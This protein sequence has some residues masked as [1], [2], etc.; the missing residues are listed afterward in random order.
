MPF[1]RRYRH[2]Q[3]SPE[4]ALQILVANLDYSDYLG[5]L[6]IARVFNGTLRNGDEAG[7]SKPDGSIEKV[8]ITKL[9]SFSGLK[10]ID[11]DATTLG[12]IVA[13]A[14][15]EGINIGD[16]I[17]SSRRP[18]RCRGSPST[19]PRSPCNLRSILRRFPDARDNSS[20]HAICANDC[21]KNC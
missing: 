2:P 17:T 18:L 21:K 20:P 5:R 16:T 14:G 15:V 12:D 13:V 6:A 8:K 19:S 11:I 4:A 10:R 3:G 9:F 1:S 7:I